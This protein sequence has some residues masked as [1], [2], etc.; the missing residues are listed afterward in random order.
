MRVLILRR[1]E[2]GGIATYTDLLAS[3]L[4]RSGV[5]VRVEDATGWMPQETQRGD[6][7]KGNKALR[8]LAADYDVVHA[9][10]YRCAWACSEVFGSD[11]AWMFTAWDFPKTTHPSLVEKLNDAADGFATSR[12]LRRHLEDA[13]VV[14]VSL[15]V[16]SVSEAVPEVREAA[17]ET[18]RLPDGPIVA[19]LGRFVPER[20]LDALARAMEDVWPRI[21]TARL[22]LAGEGDLDIGG[23]SLPEQITVLPWQRQPATLISASDL[24]VVPSST[25]SFSLIAG[26]AMALSRPVLIRNSG[27]L[28]EMIQPGTSG[29]TFDSDEELG[30]R[31]AEALEMPLTLESIASAGRIRA[32]TNFNAEECAAASARAYRRLLATA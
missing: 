16:P 23:A 21:P 3:L 13:G 10:G 22:V 1:Q 30:A 2:R 12:A 24:V 5:S 7:K 28:P 19:G 8:E 26:E 32:S 27:G 11:E 14:D 17:R 6:I 15:A 4:P 20:S 18:L 25:Q 31:I 29:F 9:F